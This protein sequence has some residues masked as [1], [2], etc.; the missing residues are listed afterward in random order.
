M[1]MA[2]L[3]YDP[4]HPP[5]AAGRRRLH[6]LEVGLPHSRAVR[7]EFRA[8]VASAE[9]GLPALAAGMER[10]ARFTLANPVYSQ[11][12]YWRPVPG[13]TP[14]PEAYQPAQEFVADVG[15]GPPARRRISARSTR[16]PPPTTA[17]RC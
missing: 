4:E 8:G 3:P 10:F 14:S 5:G 16:T 12:L 15:G 9:P 1:T 6:D 7:D 2:G 11:L 13:L 17:T